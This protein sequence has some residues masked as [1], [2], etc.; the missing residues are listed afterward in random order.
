[1]R[2]LLTIA[3]PTYNRDSLLDLCLSRIIDQ[4]EV[5]T[6]EVEL[7]V[8]NNASTD[9]TLTVV[10]RHRE[11]FPRLLYYENDKNGGPDFNI[12]RCFELAT[13]KYV[14]VFSDDDSILPGTLD[15]LLP[16][17][18][19]HEFGLVVLQPSFYQNSLL[20]FIPP[21][22]NE[23]LVYVLYDDPHLLAKEV[24][25]WLTY[26]SGIITNKDLVMDAP[27]LY[28]YQ[29]S[30]LIQLGWVIPALFRAK[31]SA[32]IT[33]QL[34]LG[35]SLAT[36]DFKLFHVFG[37]SYP[38]VLTDLTRKGV[39]PV[40]T[41]EYLLESIIKDYFPTYIQPGLKYAYG[42]RPFLVLSR[43]F[44]KRKSFWSKLMPL[45]IR[46]EL[47]GIRQPLLQPL[48]QIFTESF[49]RLASLRQTTKTDYLISQ[50]ASCGPD[51]AFPDE[52]LISNPQYVAIGYGLRAM[53][54][55]QI[56]THTKGDDAHRVPAVIIG[57]HV[58]LGADCRLN[59][60]QRIDIGDWVIMGD[61]VAIAD[62][63]LDESQEAI[64]NQLP[65]HR[66]LVNQRP[67]IVENNVLIE[68]DVR[69]MPGVRIGEN[70]V[71]KAGSVVH[72]SMPANTIVGGNPARV[73]WQA[74]AD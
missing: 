5:H 63:E 39:L 10:A 57:N 31:L 72:D 47:I 18:R 44:W 58:H 35:R 13:A 21:P 32:K 24:H 60:C 56:Q 59:C 26:I 64:L 51:C 69:V 62:S 50:L 67:I 4:L 14:W 65:R 52:C 40:A 20:E 41:K 2:P 30:F 23:P 27:T 9:Q 22:P 3:I 61:R 28:Q 7:L 16:L 25:F 54:G 45:F 33:T 68:S 15:R 66:R 70:T 42:E 36:L 53:A 29:D 17:L 1:M 55:L 73:I 46:R 48:K 74:I 12:S 34:V 6:D 49:G 8:S 19:Q 37:T 71:V 38:V 43:S 11:H